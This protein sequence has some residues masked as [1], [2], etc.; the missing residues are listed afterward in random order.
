MNSDVYKYTLNTQTGK[1]EL[2]SVD[3]TYVGKKLVTK[4]IGG[5]NYEPMD[6]TETYKYP[7]GMWHLDNGVGWQGCNCSFK[8]CYWQFAKCLMKLMQQE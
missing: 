3:K 8:V 6:I 7:E 4:S 1:T 2:L 5:N